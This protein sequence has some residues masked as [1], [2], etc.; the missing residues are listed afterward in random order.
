MSVELQV[1][2]VRLSSAA[3]WPALTFAWG[4]VGYLDPGLHEKVSEPES[5]HLKQNTGTTED[6]TLMGTDVCSNVICRLMEFGYRCGRVS[7]TLICVHDNANC[8][9]Q[10]PLIRPDRDH[11]PILNAASCIG[12]LGCVSPQADELFLTFQV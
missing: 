1:L 11:E 9:H 7:S 2:S 12:V 8:G 4:T 3:L 10:I 6:D 5:R